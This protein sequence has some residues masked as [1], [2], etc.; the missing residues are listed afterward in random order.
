MSER[1][2]KSLDQLRSQINSSAP[3]RDKSSDGWI[4]NPAHRVRKSDHNPNKFG[5]VCALDIT[6]DP[7]RGVDC[8]RFAE[9]LKSSKDSRLNFV[10][11]N[12]RI[13]NPSDAPDWTAYSGTNPHTLHCHISVNQDPA[14]YDDVSPW[15]AAKAIFRSVS[16]TAPVVV[17]PP[18]LKLGAKGPDVDKLWTLI[19]ADEEGFGPILEAAVRAYQTKHGLDDDGRVGPY[20][21]EKLL[22][23]GD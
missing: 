1:I 19:R 13:W 3:D 18:L 6:H 5:V 23:H 8:S 15:D 21:W 11:W 12:R 2:A 20:T 16:G 22:K 9:A 14:T 4:G 17:R 10:I 7:A